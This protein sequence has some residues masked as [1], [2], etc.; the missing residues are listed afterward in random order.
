[1]TLVIPDEDLEHN[2][3][4]NQ[5]EKINNAANTINEIIVTRLEDKIESTDNHNANKKRKDKSRNEFSYE[6]KQL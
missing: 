1:M 5:P 2:L 4:T 6:I 3:E